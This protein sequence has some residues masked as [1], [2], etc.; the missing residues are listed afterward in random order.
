MDTIHDIYVDDNSVILSK[1]LLKCE[2]SREAGKVVCP[3]NLWPDFFR[4]K[5]LLMFRETLHYLLD[6][7]N[8]NVISPSSTASD[9]WYQILRSLIHEAQNAKRWNKAL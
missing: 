8:L 2:V 1:C 9:F 5:L 7:L 6:S 3:Q 4:I